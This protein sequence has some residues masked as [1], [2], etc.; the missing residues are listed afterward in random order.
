M[1]E[2]ESLACLF[3]AVSALAE[4]LTGERLEVRAKEGDEFCWFGSTALVRWIST[5]SLASAASA[6]DARERLEAGHSTSQIEA[7]PPQNST[8]SAL[9][10][11]MEHRQ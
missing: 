5:S 7:V 4:K 1:N 6:L 8:D 9:V 10:C 11:Q 2:K 3:T